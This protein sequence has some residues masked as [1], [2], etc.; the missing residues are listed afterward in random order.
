MSGHVRISLVTVAMLSSR[1]QC[2][3]VAPAAAMGLPGQLTESYPR[4][5][6][7]CG[8]GMLLA[9]GM[10]LL[11]WGQALPSANV[12]SADSQHGMHGHLLAA[13]PSWSEHAVCA[14]QQRRPAGCRRPCAAPAGPAGRLCYM[15]AFGVTGHP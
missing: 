2:H 7:P 4:Y 9:T 15:L 11:S 5:V 3:S 14:I 1:K 10:V 13:Y 8:L 12:G 6:R